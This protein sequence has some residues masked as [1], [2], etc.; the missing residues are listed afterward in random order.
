M[1]KNELKRLS[2]IIKK[3]GVI[4]LAESIFELYESI[5]NEFNP[6]VTLGRVTYELK[7]SPVAWYLYDSMEFIKEHVLDIVELIIMVDSMFSEI[8]YKLTCIT[9]NTDNIANALSF[10]M[11]PSS[12][13]L[14]KS[15]SKNMKYSDLDKLKREYFELIDE[16]YDK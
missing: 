7:Y 10:L 15:Y 6:D 12:F 14:C 9:S 16:L 4:K 13:R 3:E 2:K 5:L 11:F 1:D 8:G